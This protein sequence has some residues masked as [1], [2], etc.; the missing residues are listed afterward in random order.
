M[1]LRDAVSLGH[2]LTLFSMSSLQTTQTIQVEAPVRK[3]NIIC[4][5]YQIIK[6][7]YQITLLG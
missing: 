5:S 7:H 3:Q 6:M 1:L 4:G 2:L